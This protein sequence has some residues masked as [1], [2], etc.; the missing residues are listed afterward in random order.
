MAQSLRPQ[1][2]DR[3]RRVAQVVLVWFPGHG[4]R[5]LRRFS[6]SSLRS[7][8]M[9]LSAVFFFA[10]YSFEA[11]F[12]AMMLFVLPYTRAIA[13]T[14]IM[15]TAAYPMETLTGMLFLCIRSVLFFPPTQ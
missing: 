9:V 11:W 4:I 13:K 3:L 7:E 15:A 2:V 10:I 6:C 1:D 5:L 8:V 12:M 14:M